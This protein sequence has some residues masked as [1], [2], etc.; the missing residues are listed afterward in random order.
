MIEH[1]RLFQERLGDI[2][3]F[4]IMKKHYKAYIG[5]FVGAAELRDRLFATK[6]YQEVELIVKDFLDNLK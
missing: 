1:T 5:G 4:A 2:K 3:S 6:T